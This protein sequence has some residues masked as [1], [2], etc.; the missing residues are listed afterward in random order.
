VTIIA[1]DSINI[2]MKK[3]QKQ[4]SGL[5]RALIKS[6]NKRHMAAAQFLKKTGAEE[7]EVLPKQKLESCIQRDSL[8]DFLYTAE[9]TQQKFEV[10]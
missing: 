8:A 9:L 10:G 5:G 2:K 4:P 6:K 1:D 3:N 7:K